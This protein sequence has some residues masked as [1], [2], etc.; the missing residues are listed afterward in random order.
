MKKAVRNIKELAKKLFK[1][2]SHARE[3]L[4]FLRNVIVLVLLVMI[5]CV[6]ILE[7][8]LR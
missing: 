2:P 3:E 5:V 1:K 6:L 8:V 7:G 4:I